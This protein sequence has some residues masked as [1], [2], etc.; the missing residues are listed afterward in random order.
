[1][2][3]KPHL[4][5]GPASSHEGT[6]EII[7]EFNGGLISIRF[8]GEGDGEQVL[9][10]VY[11]C[12]PNVVVNAP[13]QNA[14]PRLSEPHVGL[15]EKCAECHLFIEAN[16]DYG[17]TCIVCGVE[18]DA[19][20]NEIGNDTSRKSIC[21]Q[22]GEYAAHSRYAEYIH[23]HRGDD[24]DEAIE[25]TH[26]AKPSGM[27]ATHETWLRFGPPAMR[28]RYLP[29]T[30]DRVHHDAPDFIGMLLLGGA[31]WDSIDGSLIGVSR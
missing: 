5:S 30:F 19:D 23:L 7:R 16:L 14:H 26:E 15:A 18:L 25:A 2:P 27:L 3:N 9:V 24:A 1:M 6:R 28:A 13:R 21:D 8:A 10:D 20:D 11:N 17:T 29:E 12:D 31:P 4:R 22:T